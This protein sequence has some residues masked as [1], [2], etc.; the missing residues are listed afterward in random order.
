MADLAWPPVGVSTSNDPVG[1]QPAWVPAQIYSLWS[2][3]LI[4]LGRILGAAQ[5]GHYMSQASTEAII[6]ARALGGRA[7]TFSAAS[8]AWTASFAALGLSGPVQELGRTLGKE[9]RKTKDLPALAKKL[10]Q[11][12]TQAGR[13]VR[14]HEELH[15]AF[16][17]ARQK[18]L[19]LPILFEAHATL[20]A[21][22]PGP[23]VGANGSAE[24]LAP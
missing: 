12:E 4:R 6:L 20:W 21:P 19:E 5:V 2:G 1:V 11:Q 15:H 17:A 9:S 14:A 13:K 23:P 7:E 16:M 8:P 24:C 18:G 22:S 3:F 10:C